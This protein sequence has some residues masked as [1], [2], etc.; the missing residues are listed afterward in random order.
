MALL[1]DMVGVLLTVLGLALV[2]WLAAGGL[3]LPGPC[4]VRVL[5]EAEGNGAG[6]EQTVKGLLWLRR[7]G[8]WKGCV[9]IEDRGLDP[10]GLQLVRLLAR[11][12]N[13]EFTL[14]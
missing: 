10:E 3:L 1:Y 12:D 13:V 2:A 7:A 5:V 11:Y 8:I 14:K 9:I 6:V 4:P